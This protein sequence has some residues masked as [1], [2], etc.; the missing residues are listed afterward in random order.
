VDAVA[1]GEAGELIVRG[2]GVMKGYFNKPAETSQALTADGWLHTGDLA[3]QSADGYFRITGRIKDMIIR[4]GENVY[5]REIEEFLHTHPAILDV[6]VVGLPDRRFVEEICAW[7]RLK[8]GATL[9]EDDVKT[10]CRGQIAHYKVPRY[11]VF[12]DE[13]PTTVT[14]KVQKFKLRDMGIER[15]GLQDAAGVKTA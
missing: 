15:F 5:P 2:H 9:T 11:V 8:P 6:Q 4:G 12:L 7:I 3:R 14:G 1:P 13:F 10:F